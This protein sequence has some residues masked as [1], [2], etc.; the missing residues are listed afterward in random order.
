L[1][2]INDFDHARLRTVENGIPLARA[3]NTGVTGAIDS[4]ERVIDTL[5]EDHMQAQ[6]VADAILISIPLYHYQTLY[7]R[8]GDVAII[9]FSFAS[10][11]GLY[12]SRK[13]YKI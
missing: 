6:D 10:L 1:W 3:C 5:G 4:L 13:I 11:V 2:R 12:P 9:L 7:A 8:F